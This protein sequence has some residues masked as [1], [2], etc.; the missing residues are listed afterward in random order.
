[1]RLG[2]YHARVRCLSQGEGS[3]DLDLRQAKAATDILSTLDIA[4]HCHS[5][6]KLNLSVREKNDLVE[7]LRSL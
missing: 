2:K 7:Y 5:F 3:V 1:M 4:N 6:K